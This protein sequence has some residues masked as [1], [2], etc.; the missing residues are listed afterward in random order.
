M[1]C[2]YNYCSINIQLCYVTGQLL[3]MF[4]YPEITFLKLKLD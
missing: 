2:Y 1:K 3:N 4:R